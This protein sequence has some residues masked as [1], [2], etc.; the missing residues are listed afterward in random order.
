MEYMTSSYLLIIFGQ[1]E[2]CPLWSW[3]PRDPRTV[4]APSSSSFP[5]VPAAGKGSAG[6]YS[7]VPLAPCSL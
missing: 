4:S 3:A 6:H 2:T 1:D 7:D 5:S